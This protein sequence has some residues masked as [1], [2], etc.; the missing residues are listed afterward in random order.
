MRESLGDIAP[1]SG[2]RVDSISIFRIKD[3]LT[4]HDI[5]IKGRGS[6]WS[7]QVRLG[8]TLLGVLYAK[9]EALKAPSWLKYFSGVVDFSDLRLRTGGS[10]AVLIAHRGKT[11][12]GIAFGYGRLL[13]KEE[14]IEPRFGL[15]VTLN[16]IEP[17]KIRSIDH[18]RLDAVSRHTREQL[19]RGSAIRAFGLDIERDLLGAA[20]GTPSDPS[21]G[22]L[23]AGRDQLTVVGK[24][25][26][27]SLPAFLDK[28][29]NISRE[30]KYKDAFPWVDNIAEISDPT[31]RNEL[32]EALAAGL[33]VGQLDRVWLSP[34]ELLD[35][36]DHAGF[37]YLPYDSKDTHAELDLSTWLALAQTR[38]PVTVERLKSDRI[39]AMRAQDSSALSSWSVFRTVVA[40]MD[41]G[42]QTFVLNDG[43]WYQIDSSFLDGVNRFIQALKPSSTPLPLYAD[44]DEEK[45]NARAA[46]NSKGKLIL[47]DQKFPKDSPYGQIEVC[48]L[49][50]T[51]RQLIHVKRYRASEALSH[52]FNQGF[53]SAELLA[54][55]PNF[56]EQFSTLLPEAL[57]IADPKAPLTPQDIEVAYAII[58]AYGKK[59]RLPFFSRVTLRNTVRA[60]SRL[61]FRVSLT[62]VPTYRPSN[63]A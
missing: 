3:G 63:A 14:A 4:D 39:A 13:L 25:P 2:G 19:S 45:Y 11:F 17:S 6:L 28:Y 43:K 36:Q 60:L 29:E 30:T 38:G 59:H 5:M 51:A 20:T 56:R 58:F 12:Y 46:T 24:I 49:Y 61:G 35:W 1:V 50:S 41:V 55:D 10:A 34:P 40:E 48:D 8:R 53:V 37:A 23:L 54:Q 26:L 18:K 31:T 9:K 44:Q 57:R 32:N 7:N 42:S 15:R 27:K 16:A 47:F 52:L 22:S 21:L 62:F 33:E